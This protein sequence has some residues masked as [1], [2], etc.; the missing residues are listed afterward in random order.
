[1]DFPGLAL[2]CDVSLS[3]EVMADALRAM[4][5]SRV[6]LV[7]AARPADVL[8]VVRWDA[9]NTDQDADDLSVVLSS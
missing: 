5:P 8:A 4:A 2:R 9:T 3:D 6:G 1:M 7:S